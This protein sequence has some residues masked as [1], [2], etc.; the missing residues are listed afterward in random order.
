MQEARKFNVFKMGKNK[1][2]KNKSSKNILRKERKKDGQR[3]KEM[4]D[5]LNVEY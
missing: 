5:D 1:K 3:R 4:E 2:N